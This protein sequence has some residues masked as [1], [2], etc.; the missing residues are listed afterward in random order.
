MYFSAPGPKP[1]KSL[2]LR[3]L[4]SVL[5]AGLLAV[6]DAGGIQRAA[7]NVITDTRQIFHAAAADEHDGVLLQVVADAGDVGG[8]FNAVGEANA[9]D[10]AQRRVRLLG[11]LRVDAGANTTL[12]RTF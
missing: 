12:L 4:G 8:D 2:R 11:G 7:H 3:A 6:G 10:F 5:G 1:Q 9:G